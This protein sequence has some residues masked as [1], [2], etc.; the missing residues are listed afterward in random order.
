MRLT[1]A[2]VLSGPRRR[3]GCDHVSAGG[4]AIPAGVAGERDGRTVRAGEVPRVRRRRG[5]RRTARSATTSNSAGASFDSR[6][7]RPGE[8]FVPIVA[9]RDGHEFIAAAA[10]AGAAATLTS[11][12]SGRATGDPGDRGGRHRA[13]ADG[14][15]HVGRAPASVP[16]SSGSPAASARRRRRTSPPRRSR[17]GR[18]VA[19]NDRSYNNEQ[20]LP[21]TVLGAAEGTEVL[22][23]EMGMRGFGEIA[24]LCTVAPP[25][26][27]IVTAVAAAHT[28]RLGGIDGVAR[29]KAE[30]VDALPADGVA[31]LNADDERVR[32]MARSTR[33][34]TIT[35]GESVDADVVV[36]EVDARRAGPAVVPVAHAVG[37]HAGAAAGQRSAHGRQRRGGDRRRGGARGRRR[38]SR[39]ERRCGRAVGEPDG[40]PPTAV[41][42]RRHRRRLQRQPDVDGRRPRCPGGDAGASDASPSSV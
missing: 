11:R 27:G 20:G 12:G 3:S 13:G 41:R 31:I 22:V 35:F 32:A 42:G 34:G 28:A 7:L 23:L 21:V 8:L 15:R 40:G 26:V 33:R 24:R 4:R 5:D 39:G 17:A 38:C 14:S 1:A 37:E 10:D 36:D 30:L 6:T 25:K 18:R 16:T 2:T 19:A 9:E 29:A